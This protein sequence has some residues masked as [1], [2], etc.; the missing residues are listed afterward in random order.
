MNAVPVGGAVA[1]LLVIFIIFLVLYRIIKIAILR[2]NSI[3]VMKK[4]IQLIKQELEKL[5]TKLSLKDNK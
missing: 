3:I 2:S 5:N 1:S 4:D